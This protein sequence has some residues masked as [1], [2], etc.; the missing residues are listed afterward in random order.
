M[1]H[2]FTWIFSTE[3]FSPVLSIWWCSQS[4]DDPQKDLSQLWLQAKYGSEFIKKTLLY[5]LLTTWS[6]FWN[7]M[8]VLK[9]LA[10][11]WLLKIF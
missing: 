11:F 6:M 7:L 4:G 9:N 1:I 10:K 8:I 2:D 3:Q 5:F